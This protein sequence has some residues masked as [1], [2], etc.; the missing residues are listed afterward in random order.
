MDRDNSAPVSQIVIHASG[1]G[2]SDLLRT[3]TGNKESVH[4]TVSREGRVTQV[5]PEGK[6]AF[7]AVNCAARD[8]PGRDQHLTN[9]RSIGIEL[10]DNNKSK[11]GP[12]IKSDD[13]QFKRAALLVR[14]IALRKHIY[15]VADGKRRIVHPAVGHTVLSWEGLALWTAC[16]RAIRSS[17]KHPGSLLAYSKPCPLPTRA[18]RS[19]VASPH[20][21]R[22]TREMHRFLHLH[23]K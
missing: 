8:Q 19:S 9:K 22:G 17:Q 4:Y 3:V 14:N 16:E 21:D 7:H 2:E 18:C 1:T 20:T 10:V 6:T 13:L 11:D 12:W 15:E 23:D 5:I